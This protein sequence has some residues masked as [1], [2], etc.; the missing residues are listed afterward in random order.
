[1]GLPFSVMLAWLSPSA[2]GPFPQR[3]T[4]TVAQTISQ[5]KRVPRISILVELVFRY[6]FTRFHKKTRSHLDETY[7]I[8]TRDE[9]VH[10]TDKDSLCR[11]LAWRTEQPKYNHR[12]HTAHRRQSLKYQDLETWPLLQKIIILRSRKHNFFFL[13]TEEGRKLDKIPRQIYFKWKDKK[14]LWLEM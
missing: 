2:L 8:Q 11:W 9:I 5:D 7:H 10:K 12:T 13:H 3:P 6:H 14:R 1:M 4:Q